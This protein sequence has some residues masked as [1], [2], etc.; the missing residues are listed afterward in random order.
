MDHF[1]K[2]N[3]LPQIVKYDIHHFN[4]SITIKEIKFIIMYTPKIE[5]FRPR[6]LHW[7]SLQNSQRINTNSVQFLPESRRERNTFQLSHKDNITLT[8]KSDKDGTKRKTTTQ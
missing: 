8:P 4:S 7:R 2:K 1:L 3:K 6:W 5:I